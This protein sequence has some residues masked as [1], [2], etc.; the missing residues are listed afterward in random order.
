[1]QGNSVRLRLR[2]LLAAAW[3]LLAGIPL[4][5][6]Q[7]SPLDDPTGFWLVAEAGPPVNQGLASIP[8]LGLAVRSQ[9]GNPR[10]IWEIRRESERYTVD[11]QTRAL[12]FT[13]L[14]FADGAF[15]GEI[16]DP[17]STGGRIVLDVRIADGRL[18]GKLVFPT[19]TFELDGRPPESV[20]A[21]RQAYAVT[22][23]RLSELDGPY[24]VPEI[25]RL[26]QEN[27]VLIERIRRVEN[28]LRQ[29][30]QPTAATAVRP[31]PSDAA[32][33][34]RISVRGLTGDLAA[35]RATALRAAPEGAA[36]IVAPVATGQ[37]LIRLAEAPAAGW[38][39]V[40]DAR[41][42]VGYVLAAQTGPVAAAS[43][44]AARA[45]REIAISFP[46]WDQGRAGR[47]MTVADPG[48]VSLVGRVRGDAAL[49]E[50]RI[51]DGQT[52]FNP[53]GSFTSVL[54]VPREG[55]KVRI[56]AVFTSGP[57]TVLEFEIGVGR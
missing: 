10:A 13:G 37:T 57:S 9:I 28:E 46:A 29:R 6:A 21:L 4:V 25:E 24:V 39:L 1:M 50:V 42:V 54:P 48:F 31:P 53:D 7:N 51:G 32:T 44:A 40:A 35:T 3:L 2:T 34:P 47:R 56:E 33:T 5:H 8:I 19:H 17:N 11:I 41:G 18:A 23:A 26:R 16:A 12:Q 22:N 43:P 45:A 55:R 38:L 15:R 20:E 49:R 30:A 27:I 14:A 36:S 52:V